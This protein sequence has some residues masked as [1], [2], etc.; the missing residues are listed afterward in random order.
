MPEK[1]RWWRNFKGF[2]ERIRDI[3]VSEIYAASIDYDPKAEISIL[4]FKKVNNK[5]HYDIHG[6]TVGT[7]YKR[8][9]AEKEFVEGYNIYLK[10]SGRKRPQDMG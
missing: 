7:I 5:I 8:S 3:F 10:L 6:Q 9:H 4:F 2:L 1:F